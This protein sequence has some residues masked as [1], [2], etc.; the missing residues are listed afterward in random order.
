MF[1]GVEQAS[2]TTRLIVDVQNNTRLWN[3]YGHTPRELAAEKSNLLPFPSTQP[4]RARKTGRNEPC[5]CGSGKKYKN[6]CGKAN[7]I[8]CCMGAGQTAGQI[9]KLNRYTSKKRNSFATSPV[10]LKNAALK[11]IR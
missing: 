10:Y 11:C 5:P 4:R 3:N 9:R 2:A 1:E 6:C 7:I 8:F